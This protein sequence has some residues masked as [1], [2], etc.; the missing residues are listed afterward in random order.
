[1]RPLAAWLT[2]LREKVPFSA[3]LDTLLGELSLIPVQQWSLAL[4]KTP[5]SG[6]DLVYNPGATRQAFSVEKS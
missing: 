6:L 4:E 1:M 3:D 5:D 2:F